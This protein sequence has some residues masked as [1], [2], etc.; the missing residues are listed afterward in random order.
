[1]DSSSNLV[2][3]TGLNKDSP[4][5]SSPSKSPGHQ[6]ETSTG[7]NA[8]NMR[9]IYCKNFPFAM[10]FEVIYIMAKEFGKVER[11]RLKIAD[12]ETSFDAY[13]VFDNNESA[14]KA[15]MMLNG[16]K[17]NDKPVQTKLF[18]IN[19]LREDPFDYIPEVKLPT[20]VRKP[21]MPVWFVA[22]YKKGCENYL[23]ASKTLNNSLN[24]V[25]PNNMKRYG[26]SILIKAKNRVQS[27]LL[28]AFIP[29]QDSNI[30]SISKHTSFNSSKGVIYSK[31]LFELTE[32]E[33]LNLSPPNVYEVKKIKGT[34][35]VILLNFSSEYLPDYISFGDHVRMR[36]RRYKPSPKQCR[37]CFEYGHIRDNC[38]E[39]QRCNRCSD[40]HEP[41]FICENDL[42]CFL[43]DGKHS[44][45]SNVCPRRKFEREVVETADVEHISIG[46]AKRQIM[47][48]NRNE[49]SSYAK[50]ISK[51]KQAKKEIVQK[52][53]TVMSQ[54]SSSS[55]P[56][57]P[58][59]TV[60]KPATVIDQTSSSSMPLS[61]SDTVQKPATVMSQASSSS[62]LSSPSDTTENTPST[63]GTQTLHS[64][65]SGLEE[66]ACSL[67]APED[68]KPAQASTR[69]SSKE[70]RKEKNK[71]MQ[72]DDG[73][74]YPPG[75]KRA[76]QT[77]PNKPSIEVANRFK[78]FED[79]FKPLT[80]EQPLKKMAISASCDNINITNDYVMEETTP[81]CAEQGTTLMDVEPKHHSKTSNHSSSNHSSG[82]TSRKSSKYNKPT[83][84]NRPSES[85]KSS[86]QQK[87]GKTGSSNPRNK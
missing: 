34:N 5:D 56:S 67:P 44:P 42:F 66:G 7:G 8:A 62:M 65:S 3:D 32:D 30:A 46:S 84:L 61:P 57:S 17:I 59:D 6:G 68:E 74:Q 83:K 49:G 76:L 14:Q 71:K 41:N 40:R 69:T 15:S 75:Q 13:I 18:D 51:M 19:N 33:I 27:E 28:Q 87:Q 78:I 9:V 45:S 43:C 63:S 50:V 82:G 58:S 16:H 35:N 85:T 36:V 26:Q 37:R 20:I 64:T 47:G 53:A 81:S 23:K 11:I 86:S 2:D 72:D 24:G 4:N 48:A 31:D 38:N 21:S 73:F 1:M 70:Q 22:T 80:T 29:S 79:P 60:Q 25:P 55:I 52:P 77:S 12:D 39:S 54:T 10:N